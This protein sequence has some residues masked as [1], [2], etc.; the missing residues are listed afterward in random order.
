VG[1]PDPAAYWRPRSSRKVR[2]PRSRRVDPDDGAAYTWEE[3]STYYKGKYKKKAVEEYWGECKPVRVPRTPP[4][5]L[6]VPVEEFNAVR[7]SL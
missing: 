2:M 6:E 1:A 7:L 4:L 3:F 5:L